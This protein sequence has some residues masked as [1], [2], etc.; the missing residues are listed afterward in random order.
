MGSFKSVNII[1]LEGDGSDASV[2]VLFL[3]VFYD[4]TSSAAPRNEET[5][6]MGHGSWVMGRS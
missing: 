4:N 3:T 6:V 1:I 2:C 5:S